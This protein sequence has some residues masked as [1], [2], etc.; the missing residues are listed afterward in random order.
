MFLLLVESLARA[1]RVDEAA[2]LMD[3]MV[4][5]ANDVGLFAEQIEPE[6]GDFLGNVPQGLSR[7]ALVNAALVLEEGPSAGG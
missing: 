3:E 6:T 2:E 1:G 4:A 5:L 7:L